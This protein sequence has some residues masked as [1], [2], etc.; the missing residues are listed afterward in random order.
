MDDALDRR[1]ASLPVRLECQLE[2]VRPDVRVAEPV[3]GSD[4]RHHEL[5]LGALVELPG[6]GHL[7][8]PAAV[9]HD[10]LVGDL[11]RLLLVVRHD[12]RRRPRLVV[13]AP[14]PQAQLLTDACVESAERLVQQQYPR[15]D[16]ERAR[17]THALALA[18]GEL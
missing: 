16:R 7:L 17:E 13:Q 12:Q 8:D 2:V 5:V 10:D 11:H 6:R 18:A 3:D 1:L 15:I 9:H 4:E 14:Q